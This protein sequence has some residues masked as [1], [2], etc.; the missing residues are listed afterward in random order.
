MIYSLEV[1]SKRTGD[2]GALLSHAGGGG[3]RGNGGQSS[4]DDGDELHS[5]IGVD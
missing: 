4:N 1:W 5:D 3:G 2:A